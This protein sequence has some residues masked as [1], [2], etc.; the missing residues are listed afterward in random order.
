M[1]AMD[2]QNAMSLKFLNFWTSQCEV[3]L[4][5]AE[6]QFGISRITNEEPMYSY[7]IA[8]R[9]Q[10]KAGW[11][12]D[13]INNLPAEIKSISLKHHILKV[14]GLTRRERAAKLPQKSRLGDRKPSILLEE[15]KAISAGRT[16]CLH[17]ENIFL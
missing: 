4:V 6:A 13:F 1:D 2:E 12:L 14:F 16:S 11:I 3:W 5:Q 8:S 17:F 15:M 7:V 10:Q 9:Y